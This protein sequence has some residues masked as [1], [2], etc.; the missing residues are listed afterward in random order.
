[1]AG[2]EL[3][4]RG[5]KNLSAR[6]VLDI[7]GLMPGEVA[8]GEN[9]FTPAKLF[10]NLEGMINRIVHGGKIDLTEAKWSRN[11]YQTITLKSD[12]LT[13]AD[14]TTINMRKIG[15]LNCFYL[16]YVNVTPPFRGKGVSTQLLKRFTEFLYERQA[17]GFLADIIPANDPVSKIYE[18]AG[19]I[20]LTD[21]IGDGYYNQIINSLGHKEN[22]EAAAS[23]KVF[24]PAGRIALTPEVRQALGQSFFQ[25]MSKQAV[26]EARHNEALV[27]DTINGFKEAIASLLDFFEDDLKHGIASPLMRFLFTRVV[28]KYVAF[29]REIA[30][31]I[32]YTGGESLTQI[33]VPPKIRRLPI[34]SYT[35]PEWGDLEFKIAGNRRLWTK[36]PGPIIE[37]PARGIEELPNYYRPSLAVWLEE[38]H[39]SPKSEFTIGDLLDLGYDPSRLKEVKIGEEA[40]IFER[41]SH[42][43]FASFKEKKKVLAELEAKLPSA[44]ANGAKMCV[45]SPLLTITDSDNIY[46]L[47][48]QVEGIHWDEAIDL[49]E[50]Y[51]Q[52]LK[53]VER[54]I[55]QTVA[56]AR[57]EIA[58]IIG[59]KSDPTTIFVPW[60]LT[61]NQPSLMIDW[62]GMNYLEKIWL[63]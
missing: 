59:D 44:K 62:A 54:T 36:L 61:T 51:G 32:G 41:L 1:M 50:R 22:G 29:K 48:R 24:L 43:G 30:K 60:N 33:E 35:P 57:I 14:L 27:A 52:N 46:I 13:L 15:G 28:T 56:E 19:W 49:L 12:D 25:L 18:R 6:Q 40:Y 20:S 42:S 10:G 9:E 21:V 4:V 16:L 47:R 2:Q 53:F 23:H 63:A 58:K 38:N 37:S 17:Y 26:I 11:G 7:Y 45:N 8:A 34:Q 5:R 39:K 31:L 3:T 55:R